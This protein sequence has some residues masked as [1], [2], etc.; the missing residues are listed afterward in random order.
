MRTTDLEVVKSGP[1]AFV[2]V[3][4]GH[5][6]SIAQLAEPRYRKPVIDG[7]IPSAGPNMPFAQWTR[8]RLRR[9]T[10]HYGET[11]TRAKQRTTGGK[12]GPY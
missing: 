11:P 10:H 7:S 4:K 2:L 3:S 5:Y 8:S 6:A 12:G 1:I 9:G